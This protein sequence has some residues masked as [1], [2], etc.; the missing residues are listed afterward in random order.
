MKRVLPVCLLA[1]ALFAQ[2]TPRPQPLL[3]NQQALDEFGFSRAPVALTG[4]AKITVSA[5]ADLGV[6]GDVTATVWCW[7]P[8]LFSLAI[9]LQTIQRV[10]LLVLQNRAH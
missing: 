6:L 9:G 4:T 8:D 5:D 2:D 7:L 1:A 10:R 3:G